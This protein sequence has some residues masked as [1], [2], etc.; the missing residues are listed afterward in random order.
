MPGTS[1]HVKSQLCPSKRLGSFWRCPRI[2]DTAS[3]RQRGKRTAT[4]GVFCDQCCIRDFMPAVDPLGHLT[5]IG[6]HL[7]QTVAFGPE[8]LRAPQHASVL[9]PAGAAPEGIVKLSHN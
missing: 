8:P 1:G 6:D 3:A 4:P 2:E 9:A 7:S 5:P